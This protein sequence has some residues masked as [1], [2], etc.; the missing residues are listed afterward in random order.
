MARTDKNEVIL[1]GSITMGTANVTEHVEINTGLS[2]LE[3]KVLDIKRCII[4]LE[5]HSSNFD[6]RAQIT[7]EA[8]SDI[9]YCSDADLNAKYREDGTNNQSFI[10]EMK[11]WNP[12][13]I[14]PTLHMCFD[15]DNATGNPVLHYCII[16]NIRKLSAN[17]HSAL[18]MQAVL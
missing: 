10:N 12:I 13:I 5:N 17:D 15:T 14:K 16:G 7:D 11:I 18:L 2:L 9:L 4:E 1:R 6:L 3:K 8:A